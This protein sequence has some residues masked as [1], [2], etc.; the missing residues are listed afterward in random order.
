MKHLALSGQGRKRQCTKEIKREPVREENLFKIFGRMR[1]HGTIS[2]QILRA[3]L[4]LT[5]YSM[6]YVY[7][8]HAI[9]SVIISVMHS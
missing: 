2:K 4:L 3:A 7:V 6:T 1:V 5:S 9:F 8:Y